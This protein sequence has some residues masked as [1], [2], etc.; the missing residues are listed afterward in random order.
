MLLLVFLLWIFFCDDLRITDLTLEE[1]K[2]ISDWR[3]LSPEIKK[4]VIGMIAVTQGKLEK[5][6]KTI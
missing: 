2:L 4:A 3:S 1:R 5:L 6:S